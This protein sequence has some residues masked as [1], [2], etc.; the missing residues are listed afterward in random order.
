MEEQKTHTNRLREEAESRE[1]KEKVT[2]E[3]IEE[4]PCETKSKENNEELGDNKSDEED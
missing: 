2:E 4:K 3:N 1:G